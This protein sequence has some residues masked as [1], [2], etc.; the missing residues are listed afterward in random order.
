MQHTGAEAEGLLF[1]EPRSGRPRTGRELLTHPAARGGADLSSA[2]KD[3]RRAAGGPG[4]LAVPLGGCEGHCR[5]RGACC[6][7]LED[8][9]F[10]DRCGQRGG[11]GSTSGWVPKKGQRDMGLSGVRTDPVG[12]RA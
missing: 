8:A 4:A 12:W 11:P 6:T 3:C 5:L 9:A 10:V 7:G 2:G 1:S